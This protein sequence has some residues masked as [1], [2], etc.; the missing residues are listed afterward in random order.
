VGVEV[1]IA[2]EPESYSIY[3]TQYMW[4]DGGEQGMGQIQELEAIIR[5]E[6]FD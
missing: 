5:A 6:L 2:E 1:L 3:L 4:K